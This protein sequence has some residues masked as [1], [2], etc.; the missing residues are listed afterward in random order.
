MKNAVSHLNDPTVL[1]LGHFSHIETAYNRKTKLLIGN[2]LVYAWF[3]FV[4]HLKIHTLP[5]YKYNNIYLSKKI[6]KNP[7]GIRQIVSSSNRLQNAYP[8]L[9]TNGYNHM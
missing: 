4:N 2:G 5:G 7:M 3:E 6:Y 9:S 8:N 1:Y